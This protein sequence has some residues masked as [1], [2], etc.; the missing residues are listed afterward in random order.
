MRGLNSEASSVSS[1]ASASFI[2]MSSVL[3][4]CFVSEDPGEKKPRV[5]AGAGSGCM[6]SWL[7]F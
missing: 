5:V 1:R 3:F 4:A 2:V 7:L 6:F